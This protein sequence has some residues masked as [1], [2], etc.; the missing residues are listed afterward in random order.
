MMTSK[1]PYLIRA[2][3]EWLL[4]NGLTP[5]LLVNA[6]HAQVLV[7]REF[8]EEGRIILNINPRAVSNLELGNEWISF[9]ARFSGVTEE[10]VVPPSAV[11]GIYAKENGQGMLFSPE[12][13]ETGDQP[14][15]EPD[16]PRPGKRPS[17]KVIK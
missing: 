2:L 13:P 16:P 7:P 14:E 15:D 1:R 5:Y 8:V 9:S 3:N 6:D 4:D 11:M 17:L 12:E 10:V